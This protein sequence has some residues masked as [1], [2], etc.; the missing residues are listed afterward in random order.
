MLKLNRVEHIVAND[1]IAHFEQN[2]SA[3]NV[4]ECNYMYK[5]EGIIQDNCVNIT[6]LWEEYIWS[7][8]IANA[9]KAKQVHPMTAESL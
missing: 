9:S 7:S 5:L 3:A 8:Y 6:Q 1:E 2:A 4:S